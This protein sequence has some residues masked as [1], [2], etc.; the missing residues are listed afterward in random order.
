[1]QE[2]VAW[3]LL[4]GTEEQWIN[5]SIDQSIIVMTEQ[6]R[7]ED[8]KDDDFLSFGAVEQKEKSTGDALHVAASS[9]HRE[10]VLPPWMEEA[11]PGHTH[12]LVQLHNE[13]V[14][15]CQLVEPLPEEIQTRETLIG[16][17][18]R[19]V[20]ELFREPD[21]QVFG[22]QATGLLL[23]SSDIDLVIY[24]DAENWK[25]EDSDSSSSATDSPLQAL[26]QK[27]REE[28]Y[29]ELSYLEVIEKT[30]VPLV[31]FTHEPSNVSVDIC[32]NQP[33]GPPAASYMK[34]YLEALP[35]LRP[36]TF[37][38]KYFLAVR[39]LN[40]PYSGGIGSFLLQLMIVSFLQHRERDAFNYRRPSLHN[41]GS[42]LL[43]F[44]E[45]YG[46]DFNFY[47]TGIT[48]R[49]DGFYFSKGASERKEHFHDDSR[50]FLLAM[51]NPMDT[52]NSVGISS[53]RMLTIQRSFAHAYKT[54]RA[55]V[56]APVLT[57]SSSILQSILPVTEEM[58]ERQV[59][60]R[61]QPQQQEEAEEANA[62]PA[63]KKIRLA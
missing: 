61:S 48:V 12:P 38:L 15:F 24:V 25:K 30:R 19:L 27:L 2:E 37:V 10:D 47:T 52:N 11:Y 56:S 33:S 59:L 20:E 16:R 57:Q 55:Y 18:R 28:W 7:E 45:L 60:K 58:R 50:P 54:I 41:L 4:F 46:L 40:E 9:E 43:E 44:V 29:H 1:L 32:F 63:T 5:Q 51:E 34:R 21:M 36:L 42:L 62:E 6:T 26:A 49:H 13:I 39:R 8:W 17:V 22:S 3:L 35:P 23:P 53:F 14:T 31:K